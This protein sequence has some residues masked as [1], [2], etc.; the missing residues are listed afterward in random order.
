MCYVEWGKYGEKEQYDDD[1]R[2]TNKYAMTGIALHKTMEDWG[3]LKISGYKMPELE[4]HDT[5]DR[6]FAAIPFEMFEDEEDKHEFYNSLHEQLDWLYTYYCDV[7]PIAVEQRFEL[8]NV[9]P[10]LPTCSGTMD[11]IEGSMKNK[12]VD[13]LDYKT[14]KVYKRVDLLSNIQAGMYANAFKRM[15]GFY[16]KRFIF[17]FSKF[18]RV[19]TIEIT[20]EFLE[21]SQERIRS[22]WYHIVNE[23]F[24]P[25]LRPSKYFCDHF[26]SVR[27]ECPK[28]KRQKGWEL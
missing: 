7:K 20:P 6:H 14:G 13:I 17:L 12:D 1:E 28:W 24:K 3:R 21:L 8:D 16:P 26:C 2:P 9:I 11:R 25:P 22:I 15:Y 27:G 18:K 23:D 10:G 19:K 5:L 4:I